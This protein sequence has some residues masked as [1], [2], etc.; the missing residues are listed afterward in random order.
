[1]T[2]F[3]FCLL[4][5][6][7]Y[8]T[9]LMA[10]N[11]R[12]ILPNDTII[13]SANL[14]IGLTLD[15]SASTSD[16]EIQDYYW[17]YQDDTIGNSP[18]LDIQLTSDESEYRL[19]VVDAVGD[20]DSETIKLFVGHPTNH[21][22]NRLPLR[23]GAYPRFVSGINIAWKNFA[24]DLNDW[25]EDDD[26]YF[27][28]IMDSIQMAGGN[29]LRWWLHT[30]GAN[31]PVIR[32][33]GFVD[34]I[35]FESI[36]AMK[37]FLDMAYDHGIVVSMC[38]WSFD[39]L[40]NQNQDYEAV[41]ALVTDTTNIRS[42]IDNALIPVLEA[43]GD[44]PAVMT[45]EV[46]NEAEGMTSQYG[47]TPRRISMKEVQIFVNMVAGAIHRTV[48]TALVSTGAWNIRVMSDIGNFVNYYADDTLIAVGG[49]PSG[50]LDFYQVHYYAE[51]FNN[52]YSPFHRPASYWQL[53]KPIVIGE[54][55]A[56]TICCTSNPDLSITQAF[57]R[58]VDYGYAGLMTWSWTD[59]SDFGPTSSGIRRASQLI[60]DEMGLP[61]D[62]DIDRVPQVVRAVG[63]F[64]SVIEDL[65]ESID[66]VD[67]RD[68]FIDEEEGNE[69]TYSIA[70][71]SDSSVVQM[72]IEN[73]SEVK[74][75]FS[76]TE[77]GQS[78]IVYQ[79][80]DSNGWYG[81]S[82]SVVMIG[83]RED[84]AQHLAYYKP[85]RSSTEASGQYNLYIND[86]DLTTSWKSLPSEVDT[87]VISLDTVMDM[88]FIALHLDHS[89]LLSYSVESSE[90]S[91]TWVP[92]FD[93]NHALE[94]EVT[95]TSSSPIQAKYLRVRLENVLSDDS[96]EVHEI[97]PQY[98]ED[99][100]PPSLISEVADLVQQLTTVKSYN[101]YV[102]FEEVFSDEE[103]SEYLVYSFENSN[104]ALVS[105]ELSIGQVGL[106]LVFEAGQVGSSTIEIT[107]MD[108]FGASATT[109]FNVVV[110]DDLITG[111]EDRHDIV[112]YPNPADSYI[113]LNFEELGFAPSQIEVL[114][115]KG[116]TIEIV[117]GYDVGRRL[118]VSKYKSGIYILHLSNGMDTVTKRFIKK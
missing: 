39:M 82:E 14:P 16:S 114:N 37:L 85:V 12:A 32:P 20:I 66:H 28:E 63:P 50:Y 54:T 94:R 26:I 67:L 110:E 23:D 8:S 27:E 9:Y 68:H 59:R 70:S 1:M 58:A 64:R 15:G 4:V 87:V 99:N 43:I 45:W 116:Q 2:R 35:E 36:Q 25:T 83:S 105:P 92:L 96:F 117:S 31:S 30:N 49:D 11:A 103:H 5:C 33:D 56:D 34:G 22:Q 47:W 21:G 86:G 91:L 13:M 104:P 71:V 19:V 46:F 79:A 3:I 62:I 80:A 76:N 48:P 77:V 109:T 106:S 7:T 89:P 72:V 10:Q 101:N 51:H 84:N 102:R 112:I 115:L 42:Y 100:Q 113:I 41:L 75:L 52:N 40:Q 38:L 24:N 88:N 57:E 107:A 118:D 44:H 17:V 60:S 53:D 81:Q 74:L 98:V 111:V 55:W 93:E 6:W 108:P 78:R 18:T 73:Q 69:L 95:F 61:S 29:A 90:D 97:I 65:G